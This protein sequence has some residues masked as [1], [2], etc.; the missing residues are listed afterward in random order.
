MLWR[1]QKPDLPPFLPQ[2][3]EDILGESPAMAMALSREWRNHR[4]QSSSSWHVSRN[5]S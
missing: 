5:L 1:E 3:F 4:Q 2:L